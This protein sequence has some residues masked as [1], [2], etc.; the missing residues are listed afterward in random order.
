MRARSFV[1]P[2]SVLLGFTLCFFAETPVRALDP[3]E[4]VAAYEQAQLLRSRSQLRAAKEQLLVCTQNACPKVVTRDCT[5][6]LSEIEADTSTI[7]LSARDEHG[8]ELTQVRV[9][10]DGVKLLD[11]LDGKAIPIDPGPHVLRFEG[12]SQQS[13][14]EKLVIHQ[15]ERNRAVSVVLSTGQDPPVSPAVDRPMASEPSK[16]LPIVAGAVGAL[17]L[18]SFAYFGLTG[19]A[20]VNRLRAQCAPQCAQSDVNAAHAKLIVADASLGLGVVSLGI[21]TWFFLSHRQPDAT[22]P[23]ALVT[24]NPTAQGGAATLWVR[25]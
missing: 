4:C 13:V 6:W 8:R 20:E 23:K 1:V 17:A 12:G 3:Q 5:Q 25:F 24:V 2:W 11:S 19:R 7:V 22:Q 16:T 14:E 21:A 10:A 15:G 18:G 9:K